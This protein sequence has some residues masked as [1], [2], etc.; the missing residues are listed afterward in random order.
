M[1]ESKMWRAKCCACAATP[2]VRS[3][4]ATYRV[5]GSVMK[6]HSAANARAIKLRFPNSDFALIHGISAR[7]GPFWILDFGFWICEPSG[8]S[9]EAFEQFAIRSDFGFEG[10]Q[11]AYRRREE[12]SSIRNPKSEI[13]NGRYTGP[14]AEYGGF[15]TTRWSLIQAMREPDEPGARQ[16]LADLCRLYWRRRIHREGGFDRIFLPRVRTSLQINMTTTSL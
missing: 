7:D 5:H 6:R 11:R 14:M 1:L 12:G 3:Q 8:D 9:S 4:A 2:R 15:A 13:R 16:A 10:D